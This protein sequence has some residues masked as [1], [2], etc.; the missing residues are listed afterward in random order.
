MKQSTMEQGFAS[1]AFVSFIIAHEPSQPHFSSEFFTPEKR[2]EGDWW[3]FL[4]DDGVESE[5]YGD[6]D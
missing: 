5:D 6:D 2:R 3:L 1:T 4:F